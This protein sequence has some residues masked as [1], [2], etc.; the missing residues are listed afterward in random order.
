MRFNERVRMVKGCRYGVEKMGV[1]KQPANI[2]NGRAEE[3]EVDGEYVIW[4]CSHWLYGAVN[5]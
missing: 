5:L 2:E 3:Q 4:W 1:I